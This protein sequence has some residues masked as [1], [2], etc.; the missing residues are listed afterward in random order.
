MRSN[1]KIASHPRWLPCAS[2][3]KRVLVQNISCENEFD[4]HE[5]ETVVGAGG[6]GVHFHMSG[7]CKKTRF[8]TE[9]RGNSEIAYQ[10][11]LTV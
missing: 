3:S 4:W 2:V 11:N 7:F 10:E 1:Y 5:N 8:Y 6:G 9:A